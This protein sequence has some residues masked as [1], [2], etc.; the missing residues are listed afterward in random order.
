[1]LP[2][3]SYAHNPFNTSGVR[4]VAFRQ[5][6]LQL[7]VGVVLNVLVA[8]VERRWPGH[9]EGQRLE[10]LELLV[11]LARQQPEQ[12]TRPTLVHLVAV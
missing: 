2:Y 5:S 6:L 8:D 4:S 9:L 3:A 11:L 7:S 12:A 10:A 1:M